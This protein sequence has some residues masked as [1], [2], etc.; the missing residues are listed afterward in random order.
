MKLKPMSGCLVLMVAMPAAAFAGETLNG[1]LET[2]KKSQ[3]KELKNA[4]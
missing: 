3:G 1:V 4:T 2:A